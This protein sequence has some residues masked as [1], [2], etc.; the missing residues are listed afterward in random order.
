[1]VFKFFE[2]RMCCIFRY[3]KISKMQQCCR[4]CAHAHAT[5][6][7]S[8][9]SMDYCTLRWTI[10]Y[11]KIWYQIRKRSIDHTFRNT[12]VSTMAGVNAAKEKQYKPYLV[13][14]MKFLDRDDSYT[15]RV[16]RSFRFLSKPLSRRPSNERFP[17]LPPSKTSR[18]TSVWQ[19]K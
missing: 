14:L 11:I 4:V 16:A 12:V 6:V 18:P 9:Q 5:Q 15:I 17:M 8:D 19:S 13:S 10:L 7:V 2:K 1:M 3:I